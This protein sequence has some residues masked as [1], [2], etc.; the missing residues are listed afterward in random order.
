MKLPV[1]EKLVEVVD[2]FVGNQYLVMIPAKRLDWVRATY[3]NGGI[4]CNEIAG[5]ELDSDLV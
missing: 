1:L 5:L 3:G 2:S 4:V